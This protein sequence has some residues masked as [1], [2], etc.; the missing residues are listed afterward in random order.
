MGR[1]TPQMSLPFSSNT[2][3]FGP[4]RVSHQNGISIDSAVFAQLTRVTN[5]ETDR[6]TTLRATSVATGR[7][8]QNV[9]Q[10]EKLTIAR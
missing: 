1:T 5:T 6:Q 2:R 9:L 3:F 10:I 4:T 8:G 7:S